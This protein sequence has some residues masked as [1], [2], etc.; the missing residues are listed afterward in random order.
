MSRILFFTTILVSIA[1]FSPPLSAQDTIRCHQ[2]DKIINGQYII[3]EGYYFHPEHFTCAICNKPIEH[4]SYYYEHDTFYHV[5]CYNNERKL[6]CDYCGGELWGTY[7]VYEGKNYHTVCYKQHIAMRCDLCDDVIEGVYYQ[8]MYGYTYHSFHRDDAHQCAYCQ[9]FF[10]PDFGKGGFVLE[11]DR[12]VCELCFE[13]SIIMHDS[14]MV[15]TEEVNNLMKKYNLDVPI[16]DITFHLVNRSELMLLYHESDIHTLGFTKYESISTFFGLMNDESLEIYILYG[17][18]RILAVKVIAHELNHAWQYLHSSETKDLAFCEGSCNFA[19]YLAMLEY[20]D[21]LTDQMVVNMF[22]LD[23]K[24]YGE[25]F[26]RVK[27]IVDANG[28]DYW[29]DYL[30]NHSDFPEG[31]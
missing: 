3:A 22:R 15:L 9:G 25:G 11:D 27:A 14:L 21:P 17:I 4:V 16:D 12:T 31:Y 20:D 29:R 7:T 5:D 28:I 19:A 26:L 8:D 2:C 10:G 6:F 30:V 23:D 13:N 24:Y 1:I 18:P